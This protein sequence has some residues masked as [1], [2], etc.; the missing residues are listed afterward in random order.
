MKPDFT[1][2]RADMK[3][4][5]S[6]TLLMQVLVV[7][8]LGIAAYGYWTDKLTAE[9]KFTVVYSADIEVEEDIPVASDSNAGEAE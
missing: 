3:K 9:V 8:C 5:I 6:F 4:W 2:M 1:E 7:G